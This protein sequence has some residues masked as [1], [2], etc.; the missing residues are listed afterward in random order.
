MSRGGQVKN[1]R[2]EK[3]YSCGEVYSKLDPFH[4]GYSVQ[5]IVFRR[6]KNAPSDRDMIILGTM[7]EIFRHVCRL[8]IE[9]WHATADQREIKAHVPLLAVSSAQLCTIQ[10][11]LILCASFTPSPTEEPLGCYQIV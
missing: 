4:V 5:Y 11:C 6:S 3:K 8:Q 1:V 10:P 2:K 7:P 9:S